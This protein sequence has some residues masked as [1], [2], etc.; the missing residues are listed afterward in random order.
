MLAD[1]TLIYAALSGHFYMF[2]RSIIRTYLHVQIKPVYVYVHT[3]SLVLQIKFFF[4][5]TLLLVKSLKFYTAEKIL[6]LLYILL[7]SY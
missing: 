1:M 5:A 7:I 6:L 2:P 4:I 3:C